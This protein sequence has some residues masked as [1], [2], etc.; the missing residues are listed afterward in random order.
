MMSE[1]SFIFDPRAFISPPYLDCPF[2]GAVGEYGV[3]MITGKGYV[4]RCRICMKDERFQLPVIEKKVLYLDQFAISNLMKAL[5]P[6]ERERIKA[7]PGGQ[8]AFWLELFARL[9]RLVKLQVLV[10]PASTAHW[11]ESVTSRFFEP[12]R[13]MYEHLSG[14]VSFDDPGTI[15]RGQIYQQFLLWLGT[16]DGRKA[17]TVRDITHGDLNRWLDRLS[18]HARLGADGDFVEDVKATRGRT[19]AGLAKCV[20][21]W[22]VGGR[23]GFPHYFERELSTYGPMQWRSYWQRVVEVGQMMNGVTPFDPDAAM[24]TN[25][26][27]ILVTSFKSALAARGVD[28]DEQLSKIE[29]FLGSDQIKGAP[30]LQISC[31]MFAAMAVEA[32]LQQAPK[33]DRG[34]WTDITVVSTLLPY[35]DAMFID[36]RCR[37]L[38]EAATREAGLEYV[39]EVFSPSSRDRLLGWLD[40]LESSIPREHGAL[41]ESLYGDSWLLP[42]TSILE[43]PAASSAGD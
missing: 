25:D 28:E 39:G 20:E 23:L 6:G 35:C 41:V 42:Y 43:P 5:H 14:E 29:D 18:V 30:F 1:E 9:D 17:L 24:A 8:S 16:D 38:L 7:N 33:P 12:L 32:S 10:C 36:N 19:H 31:A 13:R 27:Q 2:C 21:D 4:R 3:L 15:R 34:M 40:A 26:A 11:E 37:R 22:S